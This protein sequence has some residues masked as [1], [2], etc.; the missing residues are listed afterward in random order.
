MARGV[1]GREAELGA[2]DA[3]L[4]SGRHGFS[5]LVLEG[6]P[7]IGKTTVWQDAIARAAAAGYRVLS[8]RATPTHQP[9]RRM[10]RAEWARGRREAITDCL[11]AP[12]RATRPYTPPRGFL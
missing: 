5:A 4:A 12:A 2:V 10:T 3:V 7:G 9:S 1:F 6:D 8:C 11:G